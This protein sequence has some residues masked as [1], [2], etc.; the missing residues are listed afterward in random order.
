MLQSQE[1]ESTQ[2]SM[3]QKLQSVSLSVTQDVIWW[4]PAVPNTDKTTPKYAVTETKSADLYEKKTTCLDLE[5]EKRDL[6]ML[7]S[8]EQESPQA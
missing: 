4:T 7:Q 8:L 6:L 5:L 3:L 2:A 1:H